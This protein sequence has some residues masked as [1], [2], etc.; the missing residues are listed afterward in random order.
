V[1][2]SGARVRATE[3]GIRRAERILTSCDSRSEETLPTVEWGIRRPKTVSAF[4]GAFD[5]AC[6][7]TAPLGRS[8]GNEKAPVKG[9]FQSGRRDSNSGLSSPNQV[10]RTRRW[11]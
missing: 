2:R 11:N 6:P 3:T 4:A 10:P 7:P 9:P 8:G 1:N 5:T